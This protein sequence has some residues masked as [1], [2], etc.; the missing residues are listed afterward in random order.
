MIYVINNKC[1]VNIAPLIYVEVVVSKDGK[2]T[3]T[4]N[5]IEVNANTEISQTTVIAWLNK[6]VETE[7]ART[8]YA[9]DRKH[10]KRKR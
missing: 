10:N 4:K 5:K 8:D 9:V 6:F 3:P 2:I 7:P 1:Y